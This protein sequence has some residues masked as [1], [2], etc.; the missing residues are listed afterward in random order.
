M[1]VD[2]SNISIEMTSSKRLRI[3]FLNQVDEILIE[4]SYPNLQRGLFSATM[5][6]IG[7]YNDEKG[8]DDDDDDD[9]DG[10]GDDNDIILDDVMLMIYFL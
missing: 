6:P 5:T 8:Y 1:D 10:D 9:G 3:P 4:C 7:N 2:D